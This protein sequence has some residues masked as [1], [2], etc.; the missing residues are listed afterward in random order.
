MSENRI[1]FFSQLVPP[2]PS[3]TVEGVPDQTGKVVIVTG[4]NR[5][6]GK[7]TARVT[8]LSSTPSRPS[9]IAIVHRCYSQRAPKCTSPLAQKREHKVRSTSSNRTREKTPSFS[10]SLTWRT[11]PPS[12][13]PL[14]NSSARS[15]SFIRSIITREP[16]AR[17]RRETCVL[18]DHSGVMYTPVDKVTAQGYDLQFGTNVLGAK[19]VH[20]QNEVMTSD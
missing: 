1:G 15:R 19:R 17:S 16:R 8:I 4:G 2:A 7:E 20:V 14:K 11:F 3:W 12:K 6:I 18:H 9:L 10:S 13:L 5:G